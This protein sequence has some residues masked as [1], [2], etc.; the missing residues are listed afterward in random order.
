MPPNMMKKKLF[1]LM[2][3]LLLC[4][5]LASCSTEAPPGTE[6]DKVVV[7]THKEGQS[8]W[9]TFLSS[10]QGEDIGY[11]SFSIYQEHPTNEELAQYLQ[12]AATSQTDSS[13]KAFGDIIWTLDMY[14][15]APPDDEFD[16]EHQLRLA[17]GFHENLVCIWGED[18]FPDGKFYVADSELYW[19][20][21]SVNDYDSYIDKT[22][23][24]AYQDTI[25]KYIANAQSH[26]KNPA[27]KVELST[28]KEQL[29][30]DE[31]GVKVFTIGT[32]LTS[33]SPKELLE[34]M[35][36]GAFFD[37]KLRLHPDGNSTMSNMLVINETPVGFISWEALDEIES[38]QN[39]SSSDELLDSIKD[40]QAWF[41]LI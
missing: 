1:C 18:A 11:P 27:V 20:V 21:R 32:I 9:E 37:S 10:I 29:E 33:N 31:I 28:V 2:G 24:S 4:F 16:Y 30:R 13:E 35:S 15:D 12:N 14:V 17:A 6:S 36:G 38:S 23:L 39:F 19:L 5:S 41:A 22:A 25:D 8:S 3:I 34:Y 7:D 26:I 40:N